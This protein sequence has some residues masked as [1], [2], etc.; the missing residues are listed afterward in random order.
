MPLNGAVIKDGA[1]FA[2]TGGTDLTLAVSG[3]VI[4]SG[5][6][7][8]DS[9]VTDVRVRPFINLVTKTPK[10]D[11]ATGKFVKSA[12][13]ATIVHP[14]ILADGTLDYPVCRIQIREHPEMT[15]AQMARLRAWA[16]LILS[17]SDFGN[18]W[19]AGTL[20]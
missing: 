17:D 13:E 2:P 15:S 7:L 18:F 6:Q 10:Y 11:K 5:L 16:L 1:T 9:A 20:L 3:E 4:K 14:I 12:K 8:V 19:T